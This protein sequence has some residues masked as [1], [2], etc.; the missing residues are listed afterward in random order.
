MYTTYFNVSLGLHVRGRG[1][2][3]GGGGG[4]GSILISM[5]LSLFFAST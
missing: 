1:G 5:L 4:G 3:G 2:G